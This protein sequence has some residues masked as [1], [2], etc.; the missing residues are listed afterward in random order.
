MCMIEGADGDY[1]WLGDTHPTAK[2]RHRCEECSRWIEPGETYW[3]N[4]TICEGDFC[5]FKMCAHCEA[6]AGWLQKECHGFLFGG[7]L[8]DL[9]EHLWEPRPIF[10]W[11]LKFIT[12][13]MSRQ[14]QRHGQLVPVPDRE[15]V[16]ECA[17]VL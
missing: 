3:R 17:P 16:R 15:W 7:V 1:V 8:E 5:A 6:A 10:S 9:Q 4:A 11:R 2:K 13:L 14:W 12:E